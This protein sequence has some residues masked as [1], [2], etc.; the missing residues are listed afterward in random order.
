MPWSDR[1]PIATLESV[2]KIPWLVLAGLGFHMTKR[3]RYVYECVYVMQMKF[4][5]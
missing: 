1:H 5:V 2:F 4:Y 3:K